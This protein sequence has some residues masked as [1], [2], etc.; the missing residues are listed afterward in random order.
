MY[1]LNSVVLPLQVN[2]NPL[3]I[4][5]CLFLRALVDTDQTFDSNKIAE[6]CIVHRKKI[7]SKLY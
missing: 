1:S 5:Y 3:L 7:V 4:T 6:F 2:F